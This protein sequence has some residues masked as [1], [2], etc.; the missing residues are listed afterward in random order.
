MEDSRRDAIIDDL[1]KLRPEGLPTEKVEYEEYT[2]FCYQAYKDKT[3]YRCTHPNWGYDIDTLFSLGLRTRNELEEYVAKRFYEVEHSS[4]LKKG[5]KSGHS[6]KVNRLWSRIDSAVTQVQ[7]EGRPGIYTLTKRWG[8]AVLASV[9]ATDHDEARTM[10]EMFYCHVLNEEDGL[11]TRFVR[12]G[13]PEEVIPVNVEAVT[14]LREDIDS[15]QSR[16]KRLQNQIDQ[17]KARIGAI[18]MM[19]SHILGSCA[20]RA[21]EG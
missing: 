15:C 5:K 8:S 11:R 20:S 2:E 19:Q 21:E 4:R 6:R 10:G 13:S 1:L 16:I 12:I 14:S 18:Q 7:D 17:A 3:R 9:W